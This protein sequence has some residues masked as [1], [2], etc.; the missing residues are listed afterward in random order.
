KIKGPVQFKADLAFGEMVD[1]LMGVDPTA[2]VSTANADPTKN[3]TQALLIYSPVSINGLTLTAGKFYSY[4]GYEVTHAKDNWQY[5]RSYTYNYGL[6]FWHEGLSAAYCFIPEKLTGTIYFLNAWDGRIANERNKS[7]TLGAS[8]NWVPVEGASLT[9][10]YI[11]GSETTDS[12]AIKSVHEL[13]GSYE[14]NPFASIAFDSILGKQIHAT[15]TNEAKWTGYTLYAKF[16]FTNW[17]ALSPR[18]E[19]FDDSD[20]FAL[21]QGIQQKITSLTLSNN[22]NL[23]NGLETR[24][25]VRNDKSNIKSSY[26]KGRNG[27]DSDSET[28]T[29]VAL[30]YSF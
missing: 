6:P 9:Y 11:G 20:G 5:S 28:T 19:V 23:G 25:E 18:Y 3:L 13:N 10:N 30:L 21:G 29:A 24:L 15:S 17:Y 1:P 4:M 22:F 12:A 16:N 14:F 7:A 8:L 27:Q 2:A 26:F